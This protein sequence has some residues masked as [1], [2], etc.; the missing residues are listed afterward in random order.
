MGLH[1]I[2]VSALQKQS[3]GQTD[4]LQLGE[5]TANYSV[6]NNLISQICKELDSKKVKKSD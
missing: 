6:D 2:E 5:S 4:N 1:Q 3:I